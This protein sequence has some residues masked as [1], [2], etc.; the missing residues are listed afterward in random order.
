ML[1]AAYTLPAFFAH[2]NNAI[3]IT[4][5]INEIIDEKWDIM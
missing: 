5:I 4:E 1:Q 2:S 3:T